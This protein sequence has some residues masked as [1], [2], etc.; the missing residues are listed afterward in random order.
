MVLMQC[1]ATGR[2]YFIFDMF[3]FY[4]CPRMFLKYILFF[5]VYVYIV[6]SSIV[7]WATVPA[8]KRIVLYCIVKLVV[9]MQ[10][11]INS[12]LLSNTEHLLKYAG[13]QGKKPTQT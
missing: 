11:A 4:I 6:F 8:N 9:V 3:M 5:H 7:L 1:I 10:E 13:T 12:S 2:L